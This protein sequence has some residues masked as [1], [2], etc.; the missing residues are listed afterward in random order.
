MKTDNVELLGKE[1]LQ[2]QNELPPVNY[3]IETIALS[4]HTSKYATAL[5]ILQT[6]GITSHFPR[7]HSIN[8][9]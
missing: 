2:F 3:E 8:T 7:K 4:E 1:Q 6:E 9:L 5:G